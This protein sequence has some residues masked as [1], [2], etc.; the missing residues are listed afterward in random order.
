M[1]CPAI[2]GKLRNIQTT[3]EKKKR[4]KDQKF[5]WKKKKRINLY[6]YQFKDQ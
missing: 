5:T 1:R 3:T 6:M 2:I 4:K